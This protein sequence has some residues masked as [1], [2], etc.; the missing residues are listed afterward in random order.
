MVVESTARGKASFLATTTVRERLKRLRE[1]RGKS[2]ED[3]ARLLNIGQQAYSKKERGDSDGFSPEDFSRILKETQIDARWLFGQMDGEIETADLRIRPVP[4]EQT[5]MISFM[6]EYREI[7]KSTA[8]R[9]A[10]S[11]R[12]QSDPELRELVTRLV[13]KRGYLGRVLGY[14]DAVVEGLG[15]DK[16]AERSPAEKSSAG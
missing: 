2:Q 11:D 16:S 14:L 7:R 6:R 3:F 4:E 8:K 10:L 1:Y 15:G 5:D 13:E 12:L 9:D